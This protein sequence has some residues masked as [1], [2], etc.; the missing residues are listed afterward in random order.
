MKALGDV[1]TSANRMRASIVRSVVALLCML[2]LAPSGLAAVLFSNFPDPTNQGGNYLAAPGAG[3]Q[4]F[5]LA[6]PSTLT[7]MTISIWTSSVL[8]ANMGW[9]ISSGATGTGS[10]AGSGTSAVVSSFVASPG[11]DIYSSS[12][13]IP[14][15][16]LAAGDWFVTLTGDN[17]GGKPFEYFWGVTDPL[18]GLD[19]YTSD[20]SAWFD[21]S[22]SYSNLLIVE[23]DIRITPVPEPS[24]LALFALALIGLGASTPRA[25]RTVPS[26]HF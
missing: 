17:S 11:Y 4:E 9:N 14:N 21:T 24:A 10:V 19:S 22:S 6:S 3:S 8:P 7:S 12:F 2:A 15:L 1:R 18:I 26:A 25:N 20:G 5:S 16:A 13:A 23:G